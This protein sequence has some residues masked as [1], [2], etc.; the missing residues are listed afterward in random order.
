M[1][2]YR[3]G[4]KTRVPF[5]F[6]NWVSK[7]VYIEQKVSLEMAFIFY[8]FS[9]QVHSWSWLRACFHL[10]KSWLIVNIYASSHTLVELLFCTILLLSPLHTVRTFSLRFWFMVSRCIIFCKWDP[11]VASLCGRRKPCSTLHQKQLA[12]VLKELAHPNQNK[13]FSFKIAHTLRLNNAPKSNNYIKTQE[14]LDTF[15]QNDILPQDAAKQQCHGLQPGST[16]A[17]GTFGHT[18]T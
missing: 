10:P 16:V 11:S 12:C 4:F 13:A 5:S 18:C 1:S 7:S 17:P 8:A 14:V 2:F 6:W 9:F 3:G 15:P